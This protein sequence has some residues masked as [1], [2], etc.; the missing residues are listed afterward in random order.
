MLSFGRQRRF[1][2]HTRKK[3]GLK[4][5]Q[6]KH[7]VGG[8][9]PLRQSLFLNLLAAQMLDRD[10]KNLHSPSG[11]RKLRLDRLRRAGGGSVGAAVGL[12]PPVERKKEKE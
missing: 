3:A 2:S 9:P 4:P 12:L 1:L 6:R 5:R 11:V 10:L 7:S 8:Q